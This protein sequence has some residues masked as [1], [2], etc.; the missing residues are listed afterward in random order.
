MQIIE[1]SKGLQENESHSDDVRDILG[2]TPGWFVKWG[3]TAIF[4]LVLFAILL[5]WLIRF[6][7][8]I[9]SRV[10][11]TTH[12]A[13]SP[14]VARVSGRL[15]IY[16]HEGKNVKKGDVLG[17]IDNPARP[18]SVAELKKVLEDFTTKDP[19]VESVP[20]LN[21]LQLG[22]LQNSYLRF[23]SELSEDILAH[24]QDVYG[25]QIETLRER[26]EYYDLL[27]EQIANQNELLE[28]ELL[29]SKKKLSRDSILFEGRTISEAD[30]EK[31][32]AT[33]LQMERSFH[34]GQI[35]GTNNAIELSQLRAQ[36][37]EIEITKR[38]EEARR[39]NA[40]SVA[41]QGLQ[42]ELAGWE[43]KY[44][45][46]APIDGSV[47]LTNYWSSAQ[48]VQVNEEVI[49]IVPNSQLLYGKVLMPIS[50]SGKVKVGQPVYLKFDNYPST[51]FGTVYSTVASISAVPKDNFYV[52]EVKLPNG[53]VTSYNR[54]LPFKQ[55]MQGSAEII[56]Q[57]M[58][59]IERLFYQLKS[60]LDQAKY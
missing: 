48:F 20:V 44:V 59:I 9:T 52:L 39:H 37:I 58:R 54:K 24:K 16:V 56:T 23:L 43:L 18:E 45:L 53:L 11:V 31:N 19:H 25:R 36:I 35:Q 4:A 30:W 8:T 40:I 38:K 28:R 33:Y 10:V 2:R 22:E 21:E 6:P 41:L 26:I 42:S 5:T 34:M 13:P 17:V 46:T 15:D 60:A 47:T 55:Q 51:E 29:L 12:V 32:Q 3:I 49:T 7:D 1:S 14:V 27:D 57:D 50:G